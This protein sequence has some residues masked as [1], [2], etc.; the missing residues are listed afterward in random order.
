M[1]KYVSS[2]NSEKRVAGVTD[3]PIN[4]PRGLA[5]SLRHC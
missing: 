3:Y 5:T 2:V 4:K 1:F